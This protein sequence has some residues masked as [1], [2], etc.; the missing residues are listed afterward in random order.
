MAERPINFP[1]MQ[2]NYDYN[3]CMITQHV[4]H[5]TDATIIQLAI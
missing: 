4:V 1:M 5:I 3:F 2:L